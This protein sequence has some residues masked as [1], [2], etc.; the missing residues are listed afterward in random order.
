MQGFCFERWQCAQGMKP[1][2]GVIDGTFGTDPDQLSRVFIHN[3]THW[4][5]YNQFC[6]R[7]QSREKKEAQIYDEKLALMAERDLLCLVLQDCQGDQV[8]ETLG[9]PLFSERADCLKKSELIK[10]L[11]K[12]GCK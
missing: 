6:A 4:Y 12:L 11:K 3:L 2:M 1:L 10:E 5:I 9:K 8:C 7:I